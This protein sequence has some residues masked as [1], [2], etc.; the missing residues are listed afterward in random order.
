MSKI[1]I[2][3]YEPNSPIPTSDRLVENNLEFLNGPKE[4]WDGPIGISIVLENKQ[5]AE[6]L[7]T[8][9][10]Q[11]ALD[12]PISEKAK[13]TTERKIQST[14]LLEQEPLQE[15]LNHAFL[16]N[17]NQEDLIQYLRNLNFVFITQDHL[18]DINDK[19]GTPWELKRITKP[20]V[21]GFKTPHENWQFMVRQLKLA[22]DPKNDKYDTQLALGIKLVGNRFPKVHIYLYG[23]YSETKELHWANAKEINFKVKQKFYK[24]NEAMTYEDRAKWRLEDRKM[25]AEPGLEPSKFYLRWKDYVTILKPQN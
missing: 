12:L 20:K 1:R 25:Q 21:K 5:E 3:L 13:K 8:Y 17:K 22:K 18:K 4:K 2:S 6:G 9:L 10:Q 15:L 11:L 24:F 16:K 19:Q 14:S 7:I 23:K